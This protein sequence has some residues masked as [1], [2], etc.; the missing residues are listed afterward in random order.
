MIE[1]SIPWDEP[2]WSKAPQEWIHDV[3]DSHDIYLAGD[4]E[5]AHIRPWSAVLRVPTSDGLFYFKATAAVLAYEPAL[6]DFLGRL[7]PEV[8]PDLLAVDLQRRWMLMRDSGRPLRA[9]IKS[10]KSLKRWRSIMPVYAGLQK[11]LMP[12]REELLALGVLDRRLDT[13]PAQFKRL[14]ADE[15]ALLIDQPESL[16]AAEYKRLKAAGKDF[17]RMC[18]EL[19]SFNI[20]ATLH[21]DDFHDGNLFVQNGR[22]IFTDWG[23]SAIT[24]PFFTLVVMLRGAG[25][26]LEL[27]DD[28]PALAEM[29][30]WYLA[31]WTDYAPLTELQPIGHL[32]QR[33][34]LVNRALTWHRV[35]SSLPEALKPEYAIAVPAY[36]QDFINST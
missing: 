31:Q 25:N 19:A 3:L 32:A 29:R 21:H 23:E 33:I 4:I 10:E 16:T 20:P 11:E 35:I 13:L 24:H 18:A 7:H 1:Q 6:T 22:V 26:S 8:I 5:Q 15:P 17:E 9:F 30:D 12:R 27:T 28:A 2:N 36:L 34:G 14:I